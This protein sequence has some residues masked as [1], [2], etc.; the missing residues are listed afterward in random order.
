M[1]GPRVITKGETVCSLMF[2]AVGDVL[3]SL[4]VGYIFRFTSEHACLPISN[5]TV[6]ISPE[7]T[8]PSRRHSL[9]QYV[10][11]QHVLRACDKYP[12]V[13]R[14]VDSRP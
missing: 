12:C 9:P 13:A 3:E 8:P 7:D 2:I 4:Y 10:K 5:K 11:V 6:G 1:D 14:R